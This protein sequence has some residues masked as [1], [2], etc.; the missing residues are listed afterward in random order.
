[1]NVAA[2]RAI[3]SGVYE[4]LRARCVSLGTLILEAIA[5]SRPPGSRDG[6]FMGRYGIVPRSAEMADTNSVTIE[7]PAKLEAT[8][9]AAVEA[10]D[11]GSPEEVVSEALALWPLDREAYQA[12]LEDFRTKLQAAESD[13]RSDMSMDEVRSYLAERRRS[14]EAA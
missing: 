13:P 12:E 14:D 7:L 1:M 5:L 10:G 2:A 6:S 11:S 9:R 3:S 8:I 4:A